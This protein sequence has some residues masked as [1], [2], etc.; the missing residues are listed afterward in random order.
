MNNKKLSI[1]IP[2]YFNQE[3]LYHLY[4]QLR[5]ILKELE[6]R[7]ELVFIDDGSEDDSYTILKDIQTKDKNIKL[8]KLCRN[9]GSHTAILSG[10]NNCTGDYATV[11]SADLQDPPVIIK[12][13]LDKISNSKN[14]KVILAVRKDRD[15]GIIQKKISNT[16]YKLM[17][18]YALKNMPLGGFDCFLIER[19]V[20]NQ[21]KNIKEKNT[22]IMGLIV[23]LGYKTENIEYIR[24]AREKGV[25]RWTFSK[26][27]KL[28]IDSFLSFSYLPI[29]IMSLS[30]LLLFF[31]GILGVLFLIWNKVNNLITEGWTSIMILLIIFSGIQLLT[32]GIIGEYL[33]RT[34]DEIKKRPLYIVEEKIGFE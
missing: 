26:K 3:N 6:C 31:I 19:E 9:F 13:M 16:Y 27:I 5:F 32:L 12:N 33:W 24:Q 34:L 25:S 30:G 11:I 28:F 21:I 20:I 17:R 22:T 29:R 8:I 2:V 18:K 14:T 1:I 23:W 15:E 4:E 7:Y 10:L